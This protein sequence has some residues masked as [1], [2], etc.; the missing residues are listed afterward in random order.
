M[1]EK[2]TIEKA[3]DFIES[4][5]EK[6]NKKYYPAYHFAAPIGWINDPIGFSMYKDEYHLF[7][8]YHPYNS[9]WGPMHW[10]H[11]KSKDAIK[12][13][14]LDVALAPDKKY[15]QGGCFSGSA[16]EKDGKLYVMYTGHLPDETD[17]KLTRQN[18]NIAISND[19]ITFEKYK[20]N[21]VLTEGDIPEGSSIVD[22]RD[23]KI[24]KKDNLYY[25]V[26]GSKT[27]DNK[28]QVL[29]YK[30]KDLLDWEYVSVFFPYNKFLGTMVE[31]PD[32]VQ[33]GE[34]EYFILSA[35]NYE[36]EKTGKFYNHISWLIEGEV[37][38]NSY[39]FNMNTIQKIDNGLDFYAPQTVV[40]KDGPVAISW[41]QAWGKSFPSNEQA[42]GWAGQMTLPRKL[43]YDGQKL[44]QKVIQ[45]IESYKY[46]QIDEYDI[47]S[48]NQL[49]LS[50]KPIQY[51]NMKFE[52]HQ[53]RDFKI[54]LSNKINEEI[55]L[56]YSHLEKSFYF[57]RELTKVQIVD[58]KS[59]ETV[60]A[61][62][63]IPYSG[64]NLNIELFIDTSSIELFINDEVA[65]T[66]TFYL[67][68][69]FT[70]IV[71]ESL[72]E[73][74]IEKLSTANIDLNRKKAN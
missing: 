48:N 26:I 32:F 25:C 39:I 38:W 6:L 53:L 58:E 40:T 31:C 23:P 5:T 11:A 60:G 50:Q 73:I 13:E 27:N 66:N 1:T 18:Q 3:N 43:E 46:N 69:V 22:Y 44:K 8:Q 10:G 21:P 41:M 2:F 56:S 20:N 4:N 14:H 74:K 35:M 9:Q 68:E 47:S 57:S 37:D 71:L 34:K 33:I 29:L 30:S 12:W 64:E 59:K 42:H 72:E 15:D 61:S 7:Y 65:M 70:E 19:G 51:L 24:F 36:D 16:I 67:D 52:E 62:K 63:T 55:V 54:K 17:E 28:G 49:I 45:S